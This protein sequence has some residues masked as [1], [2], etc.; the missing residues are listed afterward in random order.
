MNVYIGLATAAWLTATATSLI[1]SC[2]R[3]PN[4]PA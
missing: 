1:E 4:Q 2:P 3:L